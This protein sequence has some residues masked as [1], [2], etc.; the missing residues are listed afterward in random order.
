MSNV[1]LTANYCHCYTYRKKIKTCNYADDT[2][3]HASDYD[4]EGITRI[5]END[6]AI[7]SN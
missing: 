2:T 5:S 7:L 6:T 1:W 4:K 3:I